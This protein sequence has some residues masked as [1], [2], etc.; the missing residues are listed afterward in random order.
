LKFLS[1]AFGLEEV[2]VF[3]LRSLC[4]GLFFG[5]RSGS[6]E[7]GIQKKFMLI[8]C[9]GHGL[10][11]GGDEAATAFLPGTARFHFLILV[12]LSNGYL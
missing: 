5:L 7:T 11:Q 4:F 3:S 2:A 10:E 6:V 8:S 9:W 12:S 1:C